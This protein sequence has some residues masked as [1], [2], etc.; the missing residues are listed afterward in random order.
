MKGVHFGGPTVCEACHKMIWGFTGKQGKK[1][2]NCKTSVHH[3]CVS[4]LQDDCGF[5][6]RWPIQTPHEF[7]H[8]SL[9]GPTFCSVC[10]DLIGPGNGMR[11]HTCRLIAHT[12]C[13]AEVEDTCVSYS[14]DRPLVDGQKQLHHWVQGQGV[15]S[16]SCSSCKD[17]VS[18][19]GHFGGYRCH[20]CQA[21]ACSSKCLV[22]VNK[23]N[24]GN[25]SMGPLGSLRLRPVDVQ[26]HSSDDS[27]KWEISSP[28]LK[29][30]SPIIAFVN[31]GSGGQMGEI[32]IKEL[33]RLLNPRQVFNLKKGG[34]V[35]GL[36]F[37]QRHPT[38]SWSILAC[39]GDGTVAWVLQEID[40]MT[41]T[42]TPPVAVLPL[43]TG[44][45]FSR[46]FG[47]GSGFGDKKELKPLLT[48]LVHAKETTVDRWTMT[49]T[50]SPSLSLSSSPSSLASSL[51]HVE[52]S[53]TSSPPS[54]SP[55]SSSSDTP[56]ASASEDSPPPR[57]LSAA[58][59]K[60]IINNY[61]SIGTDAKIAVKF[62]HH[63]NEHPELYNGQLTNLMWYAKFGTEDIFSKQKPI[64][65]ILT[66]KVDDKP[67][68]LPKKL[69]V[70]LLV[71]LPSCYGGQYLWLDEKSA[72][73]DKI[74]QGP[75]RVND[76]LIEVVGASSAAHL[77]QLQSGLV[78]PVIIAQGKTIDI[79]LLV[80]HAMQVD[81]EP[82]V[83]PSSSIRIEH[84]TKSAVLYTSSAHATVK[85][86]VK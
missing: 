8:A 12:T 49:L 26:L 50:P 54:D 68:T 73:S 19:N 63:R 4:K 78:S 84:K 61:M 80:K 24:K 30:Y 31:P 3:E 46:A 6:I 32:V 33:S 75:L 13:F 29:N 42:K 62:H 1:C 7:K 83:Q 72:L 27:S 16:D 82:W 51:D 25:C 15:S 43:G 28:P 70:L 45:D 5:G 37:I 20:W 38:I 14:N 17:R 58:P 53:Q 44:N 64:S 23:A 76:G 79:S 67:I 10:R 35:P 85:A 18:F 59:K 39:G 22:E 77:A 81:G 40:K 11:C 71:N 69:V 86:N 34:P 60:I 48:S 47:C 2:F 41:F 65:E 9:I 21:H 36:K 66:L 56:P 57:P 55:P 52:E 74:P